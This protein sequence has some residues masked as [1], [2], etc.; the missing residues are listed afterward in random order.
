MRITLEHAVHTAVEPTPHVL[1]VAAMFGLGV[2]EAQTIQIIPSTDL[3]L[4]PGQ[5][6]FVTG[7]SGGGK[8]TLLRQARCRLEQEAST[9]VLA[10]DNL[11]DISDRPLV[12]CFPHRSLGQILKWLS[13]SGLNDAFIMLRKPTELSDGQRYRLRLAQVMAMIEADVC[14]DRLSVILADEFCATLD[15]TTA[16]TLARNIRKWVST[17]RACFIAATSHDD[18]LEPLDPDTLIEQQLDGRMTVLARP[19]Q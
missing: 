13:L 7:A 3:D 16:K 2:D 1:E 5:V 11:P 17:S 14:P 9:H 19:K 6:I 15:R 18:L 10:F 8:S 4:A 12:D